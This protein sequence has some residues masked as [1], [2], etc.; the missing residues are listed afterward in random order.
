MSELALAGVFFA[1]FIYMVLR[2]RKASRGDD[3]GKYESSAIAGIFTLSIIFIMVFFRME[4][5]LLA[6][7]PAL[8]I[9]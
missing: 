7:I 3:G 6:I 8:F 1:L 5:E 2:V 9:I 4:K